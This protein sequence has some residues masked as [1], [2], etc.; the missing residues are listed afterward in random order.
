MVLSS[1]WV[2]FE[3]IMM[4]YKE[5]LFEG[6]AIRGSLP[7]IP[8]MEELCSSLSSPCSYRCLFNLQ[9]LRM[10]VGRFPSSKE[11]V[12]PYS[13]GMFRK[14]THSHGLVNGAFDIRDRKGHF[15]PE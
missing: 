7:H 14:I 1:T 3:T 2:S 6:E 12:Y 10:C 9:T 11:V 5:T 13:T 4:S 15:V 8:L